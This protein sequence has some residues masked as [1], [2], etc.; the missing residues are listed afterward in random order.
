MLR[1]HVDTQLETE[2][3]RQSELL[4]PSIDG[5]FRA[6]T[7]LGK[8][9]ATVS[10]E[11]GFVFA[12][13]GMRRT[14]NDLARAAEVKDVVSRS[15]SGHTTEAM[16]RHYSTV[17]GEEQ[18]QG[19]ARVVDL[20][21]VRAR[22]ENAASATASNEVPLGTKSSSENVHSAVPSGTSGGTRGASGGTRSRKAG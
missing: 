15:I 9:F 21:T 3:Q 4:F 17:R 5:G 11:M 22:R 14:F 19:I 2:A 18:R 12:P 8:P 7:V 13:R 10:E 6:G 20:M 1:W 16:Q